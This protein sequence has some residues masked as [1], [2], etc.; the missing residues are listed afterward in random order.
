MLSSL[1]WSK[2]SELKVSL[3]FKMNWVSA[4]L[5]SPNS[6]TYNVCNLHEMHVSLTLVESW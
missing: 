1:S 4:N 6:L 3:L 2:K 5:L